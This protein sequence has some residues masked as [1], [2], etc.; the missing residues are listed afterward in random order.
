MHSETF[1]GL[2]GMGDL[3]V[4]CFSR[5]SRNRTLGDRIARGI[6]G[7]RIGIRNCRRLSD[8]AFRQGTGGAPEV[9][10]PIIDEVYAMLYEGKDVHQAVNDLL[11]RNRGLGKGVD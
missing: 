4:T 8:I 9:S 5:Q 10:T 11:T 1:S 6:A 3:T 2:S 7:N